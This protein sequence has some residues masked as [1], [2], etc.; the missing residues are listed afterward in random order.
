[1]STDSTE[2]L[3]LPRTRPR[4]SLV[5]S[6]L[7]TDE[8]PAPIL[9]S[10]HGAAATFAWEEWTRGVIRNPH[11]RKAYT[12]AVTDFFR[13]LEPHGIRL[14]A[15]TPGMVG[16]YL[17]QHS[18][19][20]PTRKLTLAA[21]RACFDVLVLRHVML[22]NPAASVRGEKY[23]AVEGKTPE[24]TVH[25]LRTLLAAIETQSLLG[26]RD[27]AVIATL[28]Y[29]AARA[30]ATARL[31]RKDLIFDG[32]QWSLRFEHEKGGKSRQIPV[33]HDL[34]S[35][36]LD[37]LGAAN[38]MANNGSAPL[39][40]SVSGLT[41]RLTG[42]PLSGIDINR[43]VKRRLMAAGLPTRLSPHSFR[44][45]TI[46]DLLNQGVPLEDVQYLVGHSDPRTTRL[47]DRRHKN[48]SR[49]IVERISV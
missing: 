22:L 17:S 40:Q 5:P 4:Q 44:V 11:T 8:R 45:A 47:Y 36:L 30:G 29:T 23:H 26:K 1:M 39:F 41:G 19:S 46:T 9:V 24:A 31:K 18:G 13:W 21:L 28:I 43:L 10:T 20:I 2:P 3:E 6:P 49:N 38:V 7:N 35:I 32:E 33:R 25:Q 42:R 27:K 37:Y 14:D 16:R 12:H 34:Q 15:I 48:V